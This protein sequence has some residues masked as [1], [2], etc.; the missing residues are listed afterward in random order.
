[1]CFL[2][3]QV[4]CPANYLSTKQRILLVCLSLVTGV[5][6][7]WEYTVCVC[8]CVRVLQLRSTLQVGFSICDEEVSRWLGPHGVVQAAA[9][10][11][12]IY[13]RTSLLLR[14][15]TNALRSD[16]LP[17]VNAA[18]LTL[19][20]SDKHCQCLIW[21]SSS[22]VKYQVSLC[23]RWFTYESTDESVCS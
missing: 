21:E 22:S 13:Y 16:G 2:T 19:V 7:P 10:W 6:L 15:V 8:V 3:P 14:C 4:P 1:M 12:I 11:S 17:E 23:W 9:R 18:R 5:M 20:P